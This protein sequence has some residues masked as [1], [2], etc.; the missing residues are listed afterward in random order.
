MNIFHNFSELLLCFVRFSLLEEL[1]RRNGLKISLSGRDEITLEPF[2]SF[3]IKYI[4][5]PKY[6]PLLVRVAHT[7][8]DLYGG[9]I[10]QSVLFD[11]LFLKMRSKLNEEVKVQKEMLKVMGALDVVMTS[12]SNN[13]R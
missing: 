3:L 1:L 5:L 6:A 2:V 9:V 4:T 11:E 8:F 7:L 10:G 12:T 13:A